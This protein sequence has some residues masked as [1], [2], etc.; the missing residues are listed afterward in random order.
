MSGLGVGFGDRLFSDK[1]VGFGDRLKRS[2][3]Q[4]DLSLKMTN[5]AVWGQV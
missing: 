2:K 5:V 3:T 4:T 1:S